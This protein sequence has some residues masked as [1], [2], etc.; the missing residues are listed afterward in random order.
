MTLSS[1]QKRNFSKQVGYL[2]PHG[3]D[4]HNECG[5]CWCVRNVSV[6]HIPQDLNS[7]GICVYSCKILSV[8]ALRLHLLANLYQDRLTWGWRDCSAVKS[9]WLLFQRS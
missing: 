4:L 9:T 1:H 3:C 2:S 5:L 6:L 8:A 7:E